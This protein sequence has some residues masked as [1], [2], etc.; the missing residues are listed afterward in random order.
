MKISPRVG[1]IIAAVVVG[2][3]FAFLAYK[4]PNPLQRSAYA[5][6][7]GLT[8]GLTSGYKL[9]K[10]IDDRRAQP[11]IPKEDR[12]FDFD[13]WT[14]ATGMVMALSGFLLG[15]YIGKKMY[16]RGRNQEEMYAAF[17]LGCVFLVINF[18]VWKIIEKR[19]KAT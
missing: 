6:L 8:F 4:G 10:M 19:S 3:A 16:P 17:I 1:S 12:E 7:L 2:G 5:C 18:I 11:Q 15:Q 14:R 9:L 13:G